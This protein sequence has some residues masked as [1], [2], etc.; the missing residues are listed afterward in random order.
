MLASS[1][2]HQSSTAENPF[3]SIYLVF[4]R[5]PFYFIVLNMKWSIYLWTTVK[6]NVAPE[7]EKKQFR[8]DSCKQSR[9]LGVRSLD[10]LFDNMNNPRWLSLCIVAD[11]DMKR[12]TVYGIKWDKDTCLSYLSPVCCFECH[13]PD[14]ISLLFLWFAHFVVLS[15]SYLTCLSA[16]Q[17]VCFLVFHFTSQSV[18]LPG[19][20][21]QG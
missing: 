16:Y 19:R 4:A 17:P 12:I 6:K 21:G 20:K 18:C 3:I 5:V 10:E 11:T 7:S 9:K 8:F 13:T 1:A 2:H 14:F 15:F